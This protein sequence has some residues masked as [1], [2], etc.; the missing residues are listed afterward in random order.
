L[1]QQRDLIARGTVA[2]D[3]VHWFAAPPPTIA[4][5]NVGL[6]EWQLAVRRP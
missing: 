1:K 3:S 4:I 2:D 5:V 6:R